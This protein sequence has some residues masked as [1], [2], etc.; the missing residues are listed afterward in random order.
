MTLEIFGLPGKFELF[1]N[2][3]C[4]GNLKLGNP[5]L[6]QASDFVLCLLIISSLVL[7]PQSCALIMPILRLQQ[8]LTHYRQS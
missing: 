6:L 5:R 3:E 4:E 7:H 8:N 1:T 2:S